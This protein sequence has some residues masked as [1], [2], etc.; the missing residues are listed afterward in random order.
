M[1][2]LHTSDWHLGQNFFGFSRHYEHQQFLQELLRILVEQRIDVLLIAGD[3]FDTANPPSASQQQF[4]QFLCAAKQQTPHLQV[5]IIAG[6]HDSPTRLEVPAPFLAAIDMVIVGQVSRQQ[7]QLDIE[8]LIIPLRNCQG[9]IEAWCLAVPFLRPSDVPKV[10]DADDAYLEGI[11]ALYQQALTL[12]LTKRQAGQMI[13]AMGHCHMVGG[14]VSLE[15]ERKLVMGGVE[16]L[17]SAIFSPEIAYV[18]LGHLHLAQQV[19]QDQRVR[20][21]GTPIP[22]SFSEIN[23]PHQVLVIEL[24]DEKVISIESVLLQRHVELLR[25]PAKPA[26]LDAVLTTLTT[27]SWPDLPEEQQPYLQVRVL[28]DKPE[29]SLRTQIEQAL[30]DKAVRLVKIESVYQ[31]GVIDSQSEQSFS[32]DDVQ[33]LQPEDVFLRLYQQKYGNTPEAPLLAA[34]RDLLSQNMAH[35]DEF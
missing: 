23:Y 12:A 31:S 32:L 9:G 14:Q 16:A 34:F 6:N 27:K 35:G 10:D 13:I 5:V 17:S 19:G 2:L 4:Y 1:R 11:A 29:P 33:K 25:I 28:L 21:C 22:M 30:V 24:K 7:Q 20:Y 18:A 8:K 3:I 15:S 26:T